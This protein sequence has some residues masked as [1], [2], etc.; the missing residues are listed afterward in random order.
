MAFPT[1]TGTRPPPAQ[2]DP[3]RTMRDTMTA[4]KENAVT[5][6]NMAQAGTLTPRFVRG[7]AQQLLQF[8]NLWV[9]VTATPGLQ[10]YARAELS[11]NAFS[12][13][14]E[15]TAV[16]DALVVLRAAMRGLPERA[17]SI[18]VD[19]TVSDPPYSAAECV[20]FIS[21]CDGLLATLD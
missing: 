18:A 20:G 3:W 2:R 9:T 17:H 19:G 12:L 1:N 13:A 14:V 10:G 15:T 5:H 21:A 4:T 7:W 11:D 16:R 8:Y 6:R